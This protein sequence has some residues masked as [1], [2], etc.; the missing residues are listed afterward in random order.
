MGS[1]VAPYAAWLRVYEPLASFDE[2]ERTHWAA[3]VADPERP[4]RIELLVAEQAAAVRRAIAMP[5]RIGPDHE[6][7]GAFVLDD[8]DGN[9]GGS[10]PF[11]CPLD[12]RLRSWFALEALQLEVPEPLMSAF[13]PLAVAE[14]ALEAYDEWRRHHPPREPR[15]LTATWHVPLW[16]FVAF[17]PDERRLALEP[18]HERA[19]L[20]RT[21]MGK[22]RQR[23]ARALDV[24]RRTMG[25]SVVTEG[26][27][28][29]ARWFE[30][31]HPHSVVELDY[32]GLASL[33]DAAA[34]ESDVSAADVAAGLAALSAGD[35][36]D[37]AAAYSR[38]VDRWRDVQALEHAT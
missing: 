31:F 16:W 21:G 2:P 19:L 35:A 14:A 33:V 27:E 37:A 34:L 1:V 12:E 13:V 25:E 5:P 29:V 7:G 24:L 17:T 30:E 3:Y 28:Q 38:L 4:S 18:E 6:L 20:Y 32:G 22:A 15:I 8:G 9:R 36:D 11:V 10:G 26:A 23:M